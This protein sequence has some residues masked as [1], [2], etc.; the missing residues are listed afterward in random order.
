MKHKIRVGAQQGF[1]FGILWYVDCSCG[2]EPK[3]A[4]LHPVA[5]QRY[6][7]RSTWDAALAVGIAHQK[8]QK[9]VCTCDVV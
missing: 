4:A 3:F 1:S 6:F 5:G 9:E 8:Q 2:W 7:G